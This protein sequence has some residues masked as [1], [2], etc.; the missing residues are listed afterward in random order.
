VPR[1]VRSPHAVAF[2]G[3]GEVDGW[4]LADIR[5]QTGGTWLAGAYD[6]DPR[7]LRAVK[8]GQLLLVS[9]ESFLTGAVA[10]R[11]QASHARNRAPLPHG[12]LYVP[13]LTIDRSNVDAITKRQATFEAKRIWFAPLVDQV[14]RGYQTG[15]RPLNRTR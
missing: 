12:W 13:G 9:P 7:L 6:L 3:T 1:P 11:L 5:R 4:N 10:G 14:L 15:L 8:D 2:L